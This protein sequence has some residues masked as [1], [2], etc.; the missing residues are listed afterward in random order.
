VL[1]VVD[2]MYKTVMAKRTPGEPPIILESPYLTIVAE[3]KEVQ[4]M[5]NAILE[6]MLG[7]FKMP[8]LNAVLGN[9]TNTSFVDTK[10]RP[11]LKLFI[12]NSA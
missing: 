12:K 6:A 4:K 11:L 5:D 8:S 9:N 1:E 3:R 10:V 7:T 2:R